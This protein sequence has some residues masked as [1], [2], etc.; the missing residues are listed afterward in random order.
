MCVC[1][2]THVHSD[3]CLL[4]LSAGTKAG[5]CRSKWVSLHLISA[6]SLLAPEHSTK[7]QIKTWSFPKERRQRRLSLENE[8]SRVLG[9]GGHPGIFLGQWEGS[10]QSSP[11]SEAP[12]LRVLARYPLDP[13]LH[14]LLP[15]RAAGTLCFDTE[16]SRDGSTSKAS[17]AHVCLRLSS[18]SGPGT[19]GYQGKACRINK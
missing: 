6:E 9:L 4:E 16:T 19:Q 18:G 5:G 7:D 12:C 15:G 11:R 1:V 2:C 17:S 8:K 14:H 3:V 10:F 13:P